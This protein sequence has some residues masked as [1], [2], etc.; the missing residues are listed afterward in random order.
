V[1]LTANHIT[2]G[3]LLCASCIWSAYR[4]EL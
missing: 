1:V 4:T 2:W 3:Q